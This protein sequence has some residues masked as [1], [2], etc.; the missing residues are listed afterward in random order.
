[1]P[2]LLLAPLLLP[3]WARG[4][5][6]MICVSEPHYLNQIQGIAEFRDFQGE[7]AMAVGV[8]V[9]VSREDFHRETVT[10]SDGYFIFPNLHPGNYV[11]HAETAGFLESG[12]D[13]RVWD[14]GHRDR[15]VHFVLEP[16]LESCHLLDTLDWREAQALQESLPRVSEPISVETNSSGEES[17]ASEQ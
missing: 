15:V 10:D 8:K 3:A 14:E 13:V 16:D 4:A 9:A 5:N 7:S 12:G 1:M 2:R 17:E 11:L 6:A